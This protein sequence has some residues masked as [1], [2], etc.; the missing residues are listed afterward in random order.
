[1]STSAELHQVAV[2]AESVG[3]AYGDHRALAP[4]SFLLPSGAVTA[5]IGPNG[6]GKSTLL[7]AIAGLLAPVSGR[8]EVLGC[9]PAEARGRVAY[10]L[11]AAKVNERMPATVWEVVS[12]A[13]FATV[14]TFRRL[15][16]AD[17]AA[18]DDA[19]RRLDVADL[20]QRQVRDLSGGQRQRVFVAQGLAQEADVLLLD[21]PVTGLDVVSR[22]R[23]LDV[24]AEERASGH[25]VVL[26]T[27][28]LGEA[29]AADHVLLVAGRLVASGP[30]GEVLTPEHLTAAY[31]GQ[32][33]R[34][35]DGGVVLLDD[36]HHHA[37]GHDHGV[38]ADDDE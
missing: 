33:L 28:D 31:G 8:L 9:T 32:L 5:L 14:G 38:C 23:I 10:V 26:T 13:R 4:S 29:A 16:A 17:R 6:S 35:E 21:E 15:R 34:L 22:G 20:A 7:H 37:P 19:L 1:V 25:T 24:V 30:P 27:H 3:L 12:M 18:V 2:H 36:P 11:Q